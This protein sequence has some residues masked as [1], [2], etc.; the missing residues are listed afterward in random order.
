[1]RTDHTILRLPCSLPILCCACYPP[2]TCAQIYAYDKGL[3]PLLR[4]M[5]YR[6]TLLRR[7]GE[8]SHA[9]TFS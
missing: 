1:M 5:G 6:M 2:S 8:Q 9:A 3:E 7:I 4:R